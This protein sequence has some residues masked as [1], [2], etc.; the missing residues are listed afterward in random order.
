[1]HDLENLAR[2]IRDS[3]DTD[4]SY[5][6]ETLLDMVAV[7]S[8]GPAE[9]AAQHRFANISRSSGLE[10]EIIPIPVDRLRSHVRFVETGESYDDRPNVILRVPG[11]RA[12]AIVFNSHIDTVQRS[13]GWQHE[14]T[15]QVVGSRIYGLGSAD[16]KGGLV[17]ALVAARAIRRLEVKLPGDLE[18]QSVIDE[19]GSGNGTLGAIL[20]SKSTDYRM[21]V[22][23][24][25]TGLDVVYGHR[26]M[27]AFDVVC[28]G[29]SAHGAIGGGV[30]AISS[31]AR[32]VLA[33]EHLGESLGDLHEPGYTTPS[34]NIG[35]VQGGREIYTTPDQCVIRFSA[36]YAVPQRDLVLSRVESAIAALGSDLPAEYA[37]YIAAFNDYDAAETAVDG[38]LPGHFVDVAR[39]VRPDAGLVTI[40]G[41]CDARHFKNLLG[42]PT[43]VFGPGRL[44]VA[45]SADEHVEVDEILEAATVLATFAATG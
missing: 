21:A 27:L 20:S 16:A 38:G 23:L 34:V 2:R 13:D 28:P 37:P 24:E 6:V 19:E 25:P 18:I 43:L 10:V 1:M 17:A 40:A 12:K 22:V 36:R 9:K 39:T 7:N 3:V 15:G 30:N 11:G 31:A 35:I 5:A 4:R 33:L 29:K 8:V 44:E 42:V 41:T 32:A 45:H 14:S 26:G